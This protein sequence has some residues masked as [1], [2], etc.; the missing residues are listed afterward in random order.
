MLW[1][2]NC[3]QA[4]DISIQVPLRCTKWFFSSCL[5]CRDL[6]AVKMPWHVILFIC[7]QGLGKAAPSDVW[8]CPSTVL[9]VPVDCSLVETHVMPHQEAL[10]RKLVRT[11]L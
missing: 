7:Y 8:G 5:T 3:L 9:T 1:A 10:G 4:L 6:S 2:E 11:R